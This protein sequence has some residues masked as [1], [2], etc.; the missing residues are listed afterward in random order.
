M[1]LLQMKDVISAPGGCLLGC[2]LSELKLQYEVKAFANAY[3]M[4]MYAKHQ[5]NFC[6]FWTFSIAKVNEIGPSIPL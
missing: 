4:E 2:R 3:E 5:F 1:L 6:H